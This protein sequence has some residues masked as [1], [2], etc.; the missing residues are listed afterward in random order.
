[1]IDLHIHS[2][3]SDGTDSVEN[4][5]RKA[6]KLNI[7]MISITDHDI[8]DAYEKIKDKNIRKLFSRRIITGV[9]IKTVFENAPIEVLAYDFDYEKLK[10]SQMFNKDRGIL[11][12][13]KYLEYLK[14]VGRKLGL[15][16]KDEI[17]LVNF[18]SPSF[19]D[20]LIK[21]KENF[22][23]LPELNE[24]REKFYRLT[25]S[26]RNSPFFIDETKDVY[27]INYIIDKIHECKGKVFLAHV[28]EYK[29][30]NHEEFIKN[31][32]NN[33]S[34]DGVEC[35]YSTFSKDKTERLINI[36]KENN[37]FISGGSD[38][39]GDNKKTI[40]LGTGEGNLDVPINI[41]NWVESEGI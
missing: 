3:F 4:I 12:Q 17:E 18:A 34:I 13:K 41:I 32:F 11:I 38:Y 37:K 22:N 2:T 14:T 30:E 15:R 39:H 36:C 1:M 9:E 21:Y 26:N 5:L 33:T 28:Y 16:F 27:N 20:E 23:I 10:K 8:I 19:Y 31:L 7:E 35:Y 40:S 6:E 24:K 25:Q 29:L